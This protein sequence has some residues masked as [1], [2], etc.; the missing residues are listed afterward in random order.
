MR[1]ICTVSGTGL[2]TLSCQEPQKKGRCCIVSVCTAGWHS[3]RVAARMSIK[4]TSRIQDAPRQELGKVLLGG[5]LSQNMEIAQ[6]ACPPVAYACNFRGNTSYPSLWQ[7]ITAMPKV[8]FFRLVCMGVSV[9]NITK[10]FW[11]TATL[12]CFR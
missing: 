11:H 1:V 7:D 12:C 9:S 8:V 6:H 2:K 3:A 4:K 5:C 10:S